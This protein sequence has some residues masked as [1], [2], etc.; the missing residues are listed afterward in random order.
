MSEGRTVALMSP[1]ATM[2]RHLMSV[3]WKLHLSAKPEDGHA[4]FKTV[5]S[6]SVT[7]V[8]KCAVSYDAVIELQQA[9][10]LQKHSEYTFNHKKATVFVARPREGCDE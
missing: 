9:G 8:E 1:E 5:N 6:G 4:I 10:C 3:G 7:K 2:I